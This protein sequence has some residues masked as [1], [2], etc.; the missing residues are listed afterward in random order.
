MCGDP[1]KDQDRGNVV[2]KMERQR[3]CTLTV[4]ALTGGG[5]LEGSEGS[6]QLVFFPLL[7]LNR[8]N[9]DWWTGA[10]SAH[11]RRKA[12]DRILPVRRER[13]QFI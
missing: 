3:S 11:L 10:A 1:Q 5:R 7:I 2:L 8:V 4:G 13:R 12:V 9:Q 6:S